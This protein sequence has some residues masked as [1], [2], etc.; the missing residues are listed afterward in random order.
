MVTQNETRDWYFIL[1]YY[2]RRN[3]L[4]IDFIGGTKLKHVLLAS[5]MSNMDFHS[6]ADTVTFIQWGEKK[7]IEFV[8]WIF[9]VNG[10]SNMNEDTGTEA[11]LDTQFEHL[12]HGRD[13]K[14][15]HH[16]W[17]QIISL[18]YQCCIMKCM[19]EY[20]GHIFHK[21]TKKSKRSL[22]KLSSSISWAVIHSRSKVYWCNLLTIVIWK[23][24]IVKTTRN[25]RRRGWKKAKIGVL[26][27]AVGTFSGCIR[28]QERQ[29]KRNEIDTAGSSLIAKQRFKTRDKM[30]AQWNIDCNKPSATN[31][32]TSGTSSSVYQFKF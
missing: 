25:L 15:R 23:L 17:S 2:Y 1:A 10:A 21:K 26:F 9:W 31:T 16:C 4:T 29:Q 27:D 11:K 20:V 30:S 24:R 14:T 5:H 12:S 22:T 3:R 19:T 7:P 18:A 6:S 8:L 13:V 28:K 32:I